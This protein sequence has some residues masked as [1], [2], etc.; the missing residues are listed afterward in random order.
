ML[1]RSAA[2]RPEG[3][4]QPLG[5]G[6]IALAAEHDMGMLEAGIGEP[7]VIEPVVE[8]LA[9]DGDGKIAHVGEVGQAHAPGLVDLAEDD[10]L[11]GTVQGAPGSDPALEGAA[12]AGA[13]LGMAADDLLEE[14][15]GPQARGGLEQ[16]DDLAVPDTRERI[17]APAPAADLLLGG[18]PRVLVDAVGGG[19]AEPGLGGGD[20]DGVGLTELHVQPHLAVGDVAAGQRAGFLIGREET[21]FLSPVGRDGQTVR[22]VRIAPSPLILIAAQLPP[23]SPRLTCATF[24]TGSLLTARG[25][26]CLGSGPPVSTIPNARPG[27]PTLKATSR[28]PPDRPPSMRKL[29]VIQGGKR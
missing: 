14:G 2:E 23:R 20:R 10:L 13:E 5:E 27:S 11:L 22:S 18:Q 19:G 28:P 16:R 25:S 15:D 8:R 9:G 7:E 24:S 26:P 4:L 12:D 3:V 29:T 6:D 21:P 1:A 17:G